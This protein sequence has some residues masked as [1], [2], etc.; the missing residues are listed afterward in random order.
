MGTWTRTI[1]SR[2]TVTPVVRFC[3]ACVTRTEVKGMR[4]IARRRLGLLAA[5]ISGVSVLGGCG[6]PAAA[7][8][9][10]PDPAAIANKYFSDWPQGADPAEVGR[11]IAN[12]FAARGFDFQVNSLHRWII[13]PEICAWYGSL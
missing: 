11:R 3:S 1:S 13:Y 10:A 5:L 6:T 4:R 2:A 9:R 8:D 7:P 12:N